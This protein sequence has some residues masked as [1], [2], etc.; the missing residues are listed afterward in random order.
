MFVGYKEGSL[1]LAE[2]RRNRYFS[3]EV[4]SLKPR[5]YLVVSNTYVANVGQLLE[6]YT[7]SLAVLEFGESPFEMTVRQYWFFSYPI[8]EISKAF[9]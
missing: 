9:H 3:D 5:S 2:A 4:L 1:H 6:C 7:L 8:I